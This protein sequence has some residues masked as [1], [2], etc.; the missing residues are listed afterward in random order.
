MEASH[1]IYPTLQGGITQE[2]EE[3]ETG[4]DVSAATYPP[5]VFGA[6]DPHLEVSIIVTPTSGAGDRVTRDTVP[7]PASED[8][9][10]IQGAEKVIPL[11]PAV[12]HQELRGLYAERATKLVSA[13]QNEVKG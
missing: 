8:A 11:L 12:S 10:H 5:S 6:S 3:Q 1:L 9:R 2:H 7:V 4:P 13:S